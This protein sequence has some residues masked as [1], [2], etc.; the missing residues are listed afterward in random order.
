S[1]DATTLQGLV[2]FGF[3]FV[4][5]TGAGVATVRPRLGASLLVIAAIG[6]TVAISW[7]AIGGAPCF[8][9]AAVMGFLD[10][11]PSTPDDAWEQAHRGQGSISGGTVHAN[12]ECV[13]C[14]VTVLESARF[15][16][17]CGTKVEG[18]ALTPEIY[19]AAEWRQ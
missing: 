4:G 8:L 2:A 10:R 15:C 7:G 18:G 14:G 6:V 11:S 3:C 12:R 17:N 9:I 19:A 1:G 13:Q 5:L 16:P